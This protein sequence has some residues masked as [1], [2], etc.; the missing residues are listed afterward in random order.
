MTLIPA[1][2][3]KLQFYDDFVGPDIVVR[4]TLIPARELKLLSQISFCA[5]L[6]S[7]N[8]PDSRKGIETAVRLVGPYCTSRL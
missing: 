5:N 3:L 6:F 1:R 2:E 7:Q 4:M 8:D